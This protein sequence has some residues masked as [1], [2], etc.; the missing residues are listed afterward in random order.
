MSAEAAPIAAAR[1]R[2]K[3]WAIAIVVVLFLAVAGVA[4]FTFLKPKSSS[5]TQV[6]S[7]V[8]KKQKL[9][10]LV[11][12]TGSAVVA[13]SVAVNPPISGTVEKL[14]VSL[15]ETVSAGDDLYTIS[16]E[17]VDT[18]YLKAKASL[19]QAKQSQKQAQ[20]SLQQAQNQLYAAKTAQI[21]AEQSLETLESQPAT[22]PGHADSVELAKREVTSAKKSVSSAKTGVS[23]AELGVQVAAA[24]LSSS[25]DAYAEAV[26][27]TK[28]T[29]VTATAD[30]V[31]TALPI[32]VGSEVS[33]G[34][35]TSSGSSSASGGSSSGGASGST[36]TS[37]GSSSGSASSG[38]AVT[39]S[40]VTDLKV[41][42]AVSEVD[43]PSLKTGQKADITFDAIQG[44]VF[45]G[46]VSLV[47]PNGSSSSG[48]VSYNVDLTLDS[49]D[50]LL[51]PDMTATADIKTLVAENVLVVP[52]AAVKTEGATKYVQVVGGN[53]AMSKTVVKVG[54]SNDTLTEVTSGL[55]EGARVSTGATTSSATSGSSSQRQGGGFMMGG[56]GPPDGGPGRD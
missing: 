49:Q 28:D 47:S 42:I 36:G 50:P 24:N 48:V 23:G 55:T 10:V 6:S 29:V 4:A 37:S 2:K 15:G 13:D 52:N 33:A 34:T 45:T 18:A 30:G 27:D 53:G 21:K 35:S 38:S 56:G 54:A 25:Q 39:I 19:L 16:S 32:S 17:N 43:V 40:N 8:V 41:Q 11:S 20:Q 31:I 9:E 46:T 51:K 7:A 3:G 22:M 14:Y 12:G 5:S 26:A 44:K 1:K